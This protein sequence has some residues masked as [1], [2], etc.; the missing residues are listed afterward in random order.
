MQ[1]TLTHMN[2]HYFETSQVLG[3]SAAIISRNPT[4]QAAKLGIEMRQ[5]IVWQSLCLFCLY[6]VMNRCNSLGLYNYLEELF[7][8]SLFLKYVYTSIAH[9]IKNPL[10]RTSENYI[11]SKS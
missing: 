1:I 4:P 7:Q 8:T 10:R 2:T 5:W 11:F 9:R 6:L 3:S